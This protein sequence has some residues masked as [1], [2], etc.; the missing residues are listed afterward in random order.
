MYF[1]YTQAWIVLVFRALY[2]EYV[3]KDRVKWEK[4]KRFATDPSDAFS[5]KEKE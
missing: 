5:G 3:V 2:Q 4:T 1:T